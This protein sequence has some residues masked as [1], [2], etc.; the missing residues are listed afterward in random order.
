MSS[1]RCISRG[2]QNCHLQTV[3]AGQGKAGQGRANPPPVDSIDRIHFSFQEQRLELPE[4]IPPARDG[5]HKPY[6]AELMWLVLL[7]S[8]L[9]GYTWRTKLDTM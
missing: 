5:F 2:P 9:P 7:D 6:S 8:Q 4:S 1:G 3:P